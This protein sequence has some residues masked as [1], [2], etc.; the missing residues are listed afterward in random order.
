MV[1]GAK[2]ARITQ[3]GSLIIRDRDERK[4][5]KS[6]V[7]WHK[8]GEIQSAMQRGQSPIGEIVDQRGVNYIDVE[9]KNVELVDPTADLVQ[10]DYVV[11]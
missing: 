4:I 6:R 9:V 8:I 1:D 10:H 5:A 2:P 11:R 3:M 7:E